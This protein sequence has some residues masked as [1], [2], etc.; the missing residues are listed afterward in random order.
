MSTEYVV[1][2][3]KDRRALRSIALTTDT[4]LLTATGNDFSFDDIFSRQIEALGRAGDVLMIHTTSGNS[5]NC[6]KAAAAARKIGVKTICLTA[7]DGGKIKPM[8]DL[9]I[10]VPVDRTDRAQEIHLNIQHAICEMIDDEV[11][12]G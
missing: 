5:S 8:V 10:I 9:C 4:S 7:R 11:A 2:Y 1:R 12:G 3:K 6:I